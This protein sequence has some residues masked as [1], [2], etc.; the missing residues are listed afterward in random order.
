MIYG[1]NDK[2]PFSKMLLFAT[3]MVL[4]VFVATVLIANI[5]GV[6]VS[7][8]LVGAGISTLIYVIC[9]K[10]QSPMFVSNSGAF[11]APVLAAFAMGGYTAIAI[12]GLVTAI[13][14][15]FF[16]FLFTKIS[17]EKIYKIFPRALIGAITAVIGINLMKFI[18]TYIQAEGTI[19][20]WNVSIAFVTMLAITII[21]HYSK[22]LFKILPFLAGTLIGYLYAVLLTVLNLY[23]VI[24][25]EVFQDMP[26]FAIPT[27]AFTQW[28]PIQ[29]MTLIPIIILYI[30][31]TVS[32]ICECLSDHAAL[33]GIIE[34]DLYKTPGLPRIFV[35]EGLANIVGSCLGGLGICSY[36]ES[37]ACIG[38]SK[39]A[40][41]QVTVAAAILLATL[42]FLAPVQIFIAS[43]PSCVFAGAAMILYG[44]ITC[45][46]I[47]MLQQVDLNIQKNLIITSVVISLGSCGLI[48]GGAVLS[49]SGT[50]LALIAGIILNLILHDTKEM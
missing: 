34:T 46:G 10:G 28:Q 38:F 2:L 22:G 48:I 23:P 5:C 43:I 50:A 45:S 8:A 24:S 42:G 13:V 41:T 11:V 7:G 27:F 35:G 16:G 14:Y 33:S 39:V 17:I 26:L 9:T 49:F 37:V 30:A 21:S 25:F 47:K 32:A 12:G 44:Y 20:L 19:N 3:Q 4:S 15:I 1:V 18:P 6:A 40:S 31:Y 36:G 29:L